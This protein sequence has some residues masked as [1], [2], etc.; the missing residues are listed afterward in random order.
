MVKAADFRKTFFA[1]AIILFVFF[2]GGA[3]KAPAEGHR[4]ARTEKFQNRSTD[5]VKIRSV[6]THKI[7]NKRVLDKAED[8]LQAMPAGSLSLMSSL[9]DRITADDDAPGA[10]IAYSLVTAMIVLL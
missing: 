7:S 8:K 2:A 5:M 6:L 4:T 9:C 10:D 1:L 3:P